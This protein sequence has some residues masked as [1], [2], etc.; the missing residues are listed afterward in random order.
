MK[1]II[2][3]ISWCILLI[4]PIS[5]TAQN[6]KFDKQ[7]NNVS[8][9]AQMGYKVDSKIQSDR[10]QA[11][12]LMAIWDSLY[13][14][15]KKLQIT[16][17][18][19]DTIW[20]KLILQ[21]IYWAN[22]N[23][24]LKNSTRLH[25]YLAHIYHANKLF[26]K[27]VPIQ[28]KL[29]QSSG[30]LTKIQEQKTYTQLE[31]AFVQT[32]EFASA[33]AIRKQRLNKGLAASSYDLYQEF[34]LHE[35]AINEFLNYENPKREKIVD[36][37]KY[38]RILG[39]LYFENGEIDSARK[40]FEIGLKLCERNI[41]KRGKIIPTKIHLS[42]L[43]NFKGLL[44]RCYMDQGAY[45][46]AIQLLKFDIDLSNEDTNNKIFKM[47]H[48]A[49]CYIQLN[50]SPDALIYI[51]ELEKLILHKEDKRMFIRFYELKFKYFEFTKEYD[52]AYYYANQ[53]IKLKDRHTASIS[54]NQAILLLSNIEA[55]ARKKDLLITKANLEIE[56]VDK[57][58]QNASL[59]ASI[60]VAIAVSITLLLLFIYTIQK[61]KSRVIIE[62]K[63]EENEL[64]LK[65]LHHRVKNNLQV[66]YSLINL[67]K[68]R[69]E[70]PELNE[71]LSMVQNRIKTMSLVHQNLQENNSLKDV[72]L[73][74]YIKTI[75]E[76]LK[77][78]YLND[79]K[80]ITVKLNVDN[81]IAFTMDKSITIG[82]LINE[83]MSNSLK[84]AFNGR[85]SGEISITIQVIQDGFQMKVSD[86]GN[87]FIAD[88]SKTKS[89]G[90]Y[91]IKNLVRQMQGK[92]EVDSIEGT[93][94]LI[95]FKI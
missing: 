68:R 57:K 33:L 31:K 15:G 19:P 63:N 55:D 38:Y 73:A 76:Y 84:Y 72:N 74:A 78:L 60:F 89:L 51:K 50:K 30:Y 86:N 53:Y 2:S 94:Y 61:N 82:L 67:Q 22:K 32:N 83:I 80:E 69:L 56:R 36:Q 66:I 8:K 20:E 44:G 64:L 93:T 25:Y 62:K 39:V 4:L 95:Y 17:T 21:E 71:T 12:R 48:L 27:S 47:I 1:R 24:D 81:N 85:S 70:T 7:Q 34:E 40:Y 28:I 23:K 43:A 6:S 58:A 14:I 16:N 46:K 11:I 3:I 88:D 45:Q 10:P 37:Y 29:L 90:M 79:E 35:L 42:N 87:G 13:D 49:N 59:W 5:M 75:S 77:S 41:I 52:S 9:L 26:S 65:E 91:L 18:L 92:Y 54:K